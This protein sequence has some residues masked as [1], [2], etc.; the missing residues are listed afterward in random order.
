MLRITVSLVGASLLALAPAHADPSKISVADYLKAWDA[1]DREALKKELD[2]TGQ[3]NFDN[4]PNAK[5]VTEKMG[6]T[7]K[8]YR[9]AYE[10]D[11]AAGVTLKT[12]L[13][14]G[15]AELDTDVLVPHLQSYDETARKKTSLAQAFADLMAKT[16]PCG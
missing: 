7:A 11:R 9:A 3:I 15:A 14:E 1:M 8:A 4:H 2:E 16:Y 5:F 12:C 10:A 6:E 13:P